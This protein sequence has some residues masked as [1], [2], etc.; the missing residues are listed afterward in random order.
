MT[1]SRSI[2]LA[3]SVFALLP[4]GLVGQSLQDFEQRVTESTLSNGLKVVL[5]ER[6]DAPVAAFVNWVDVGSVNEVPGITGISHMF[7][8]M[9][10]KGTSVVGTTDAEAEA[11][12]LDRVDEIY[13]EIEKAR[14]EGDEVRLAEL[15]AAFE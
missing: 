7:E 12:A 15:E 2:A 3:C 6:H 5:V 8:H 9:A 13:A 10:F 4:H 1:R 14:R 11:D